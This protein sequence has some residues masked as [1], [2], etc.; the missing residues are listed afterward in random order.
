M[1]AVTIAVAIGQ[2]TKTRRGANLQ[3]REGLRQTR[4]ERQ[5][6]G[7]T[8]GL[9]RLCRPF[10]HQRANR[11]AMVHDAVVK[12]VP[13]ARRAA[14]MTRRGEQQ[15]RLAFRRRQGQQEI[16]NVVAFGNPMA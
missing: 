11:I 3:Q 14:E 8:A 1:P 12:R 16:E 5:Q 2:Q 4:E 13:V 10:E 7:A 6:R 9:V 15:I